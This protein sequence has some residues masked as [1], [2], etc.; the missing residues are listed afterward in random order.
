MNKTSLWTPEFLA[1]CLQRADPLADNAIARIV[2]NNGS[3]E[4]L[5]QTH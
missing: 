3:D 5:H 4:A 1:Q 2:E